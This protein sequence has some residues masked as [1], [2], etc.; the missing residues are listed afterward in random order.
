MKLYTQKKADGRAAGT[1]G[2]G[3][4]Q[5][6]RICIISVRITIKNTGDTGNFNVII[7]LEL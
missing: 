4:V 1:D 5:Q 7:C 2:S 6:T 3:K